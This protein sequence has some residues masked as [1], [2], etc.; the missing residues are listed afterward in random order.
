MHGDR[1]RLK[2][3]VLNLLTN[4]I[5]YNCEDGRV[6]ISLRRDNNTLILSVEDTG[7]GIPADSLP[8]IFERFYRVPDQETSVKGTGL[9]LVIAKRIARNHQGDIEVESKVGE[10]S[11]FRL[12]LPITQPASTN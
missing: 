5:K 1:N 8:H 3:L 10:G 4:A 2:Q 9:G 11:V 6:M 12:R 7:C